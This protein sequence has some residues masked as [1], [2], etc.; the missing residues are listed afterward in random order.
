MTVNR[1]EVFRLAWVW[2]KQDLWSRRAPASQ[3][4]AFFRAA[5]SRAW[6]DLR[7]QAVR[8]AETILHAANARPAN[9]LRALIVTLENQDRL[10][11]FDRLELRNLQS[12]L[13]LVS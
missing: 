7:A 10:T 1:A 11:H 12:E 5:L 4:R 6:A 13:R 9:V 3:L 2:A 8:A